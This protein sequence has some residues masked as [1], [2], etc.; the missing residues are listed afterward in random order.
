MGYDASA[1]PF[2]GQYADTS[3]LPPSRWAGINEGGGVV[4]QPFRQALGQASPARPASSG[5]G[6]WDWLTGTPTGFL[7]QALSG[8]AIQ[9]GANPAYAN[10][11]GSAANVV[12]SIINP[13]L[14]LANTLIG[15]GTNYFG[16][17]YNP[18]YGFGAPSFASSYTLPEPSP[19]PQPALS[20]SSGGWFGG[21]SGW[22]IE[23]TTPAF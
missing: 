15:A 6:F 5:G 7:G 16:A 10:L 23:E 20:G 8:M 18:R 17:N 12:P 14:G 9:R 22:T 4:G 3:G 21:G 13:F 11:G 1:R 19:A 2:G